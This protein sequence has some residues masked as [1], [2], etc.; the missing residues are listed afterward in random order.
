MKIL[1]INPPIREQSPATFPPL[2]LASVASSLRR[3]GH[4]V[5]M[6]D[7]NMLRPSR[8]EVINVL[9][10][11]DYRLIG[12]SGLITTYKYLTFLIPLLRDIYSVPIMIGG[13]GVKSAPYTYIENLAPDYVVLGEGERAAVDIA[14]ALDWNFT[15]P[16]TEIVYGKNVDNLDH[17]PMPAYD[18]LDMDT[19]F[20]RVM[21]DKA[22][23][24]EGVILAGRGCSMSCNFCYHV[25][26]K[27]IRYRS[28]PSL[29]DEME[30]LMRTYNLSS[31]HIGDECLTAR[32]SFVVEFCQAIVERGL[33][34][35][36][37]AF[38]RLDTINEEM[39]ALMVLSLIHI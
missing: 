7:L 5:D 14:S 29:L 32:R 22:A 19:Y 11:G 24:K 35:T 28:V 2:G 33:D 20:S 10:Y 18:L 26:G 23:S 8:D 15:R 34:I 3:A 6:L 9:P 1:L 30:H 25:F 27:G 21:F 13:G 4:S 39:I 17:L 37:S 31:F 38:S 12:V 36:W 16:H